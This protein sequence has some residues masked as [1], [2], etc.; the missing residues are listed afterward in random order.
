MIILKL[1][2]IIK[3]I[4][5]EIK[6]IKIDQS[7]LIKILINDMIKVRFVFAKTN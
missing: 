4:L 3:M 2:K 5:K 6:I 1:M 7:N